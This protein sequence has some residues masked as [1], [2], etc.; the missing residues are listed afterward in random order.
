M[1]ADLLHLSAEVGIV[2]RFG[3]DCDVTDIGADLQLGASGAGADTPLDA[4]PF[5]RGSRR[6]I[7]AVDGDPADIGLG[8]DFAGPLRID[9]K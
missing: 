7:K 9:T 3:G 4:I 1:P 2:T 6:E 5:G 8:V